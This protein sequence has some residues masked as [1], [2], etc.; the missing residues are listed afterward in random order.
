MMLILKDLQIH[1]GSIF[2]GEWNCRDLVKL[3]LSL[4]ICRRHGK[5]Q[6]QLH[7]SFRM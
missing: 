7:Q 6:M 5:I 1:L 2:A 4:E 3:A